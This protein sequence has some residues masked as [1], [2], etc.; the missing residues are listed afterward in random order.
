MSMALKFYDK[1]AYSSQMRIK[2]PKEIL[3]VT[4]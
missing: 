2:N 3:N 4:L 1:P